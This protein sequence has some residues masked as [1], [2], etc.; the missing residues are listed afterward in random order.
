MFA[1]KS[2]QACCLASAGFESE[3]LKQCLDFDG[4]VL[5]DICQALRRRR[6]RYEDICFLNENVLLDE[7]V[8]NVTEEL[9]YDVL[10]KLAL[11]TW[12]FD[13]SAK[14]PSRRLFLFLEQPEGKREKLYEDLCVQYSSQTGKCVSYRQFS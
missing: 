11:L 4:K 7:H 9:T 12:H 6:Y 1:L 10:F 14:P 5:L 8:R 3:M 2:L 13:A